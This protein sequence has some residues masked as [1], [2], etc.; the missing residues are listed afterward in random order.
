VA[1]LIHLIII[2]D[3]PFVC[4]SL[5]TILAAQPDIEVLATG[6]NGAE[7]EDLYRLHQPDILLTDIQM[8]K[9]SGLEAAA[10][11][12]AEWPEAKIVLLTTFA[13]DQ[14]I[15]DALRIGT[16]GYL[17]K[18]DVATIAPALRLVM[19]GQ[20]VLGN[21][22]FGRMDKLMSEGLSQMESGHSGGAESGD[23]SSSSSSQENNPLSALTNREYQVVEL[24]ALGLD[25][26]QIAAKLY[27]SEGTVRNT[28]SVILQKLALKNR[29]QLAV[30]YYRR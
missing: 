21:E 28:I 1:S 13:D 16:K 27:I 23:S 30:L 29:T 19:S 4:D 8:P 11:I 20:S 26:R 3:D 6:Q 10:N 14:Y 17:I 7:A 2:D 15:L 18:Q 12:L 25:N 22:V 5:K 9:R 24:V